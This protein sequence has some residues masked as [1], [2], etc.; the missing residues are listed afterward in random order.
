[1]TADVEEADMEIGW[2]KRH[3]PSL[4]VVLI[5]EAS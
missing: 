3:A 4:L 1:M 2:K 5:D